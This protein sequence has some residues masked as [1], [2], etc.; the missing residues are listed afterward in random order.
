M[1]KDKKPHHNIKKWKEDWLLTEGYNFVEVLPWNPDSL[2]QITIRQTPQQK[3]FLTLRYHYMKIAFY[4]N[5]ANIIFIKEA[6]INNVE[7][8]IIDLSEHKDQLANTQVS[9]I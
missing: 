3:L 5:N 2:T 1:I 6:F 7:E 9:A 4:D 8:T